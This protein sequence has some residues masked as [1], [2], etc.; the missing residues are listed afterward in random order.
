MDDGYLTVKGHREASNG[1]SR[2]S[3]KFSQTF[4]LDPSVDLDK[5]TASLKNGVLVV[6]APKDM[7]KLEASIRR[8]P[9]TAGSPAVE[10][11][12]AKEAKQGVEI[13]VSE[14]DPETEA[15]DM[16]VSADDV[17]AE[18]SDEIDLDKAGN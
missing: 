1:S 3:S 16:A 15:R 14:T 11:A 18:E 5:F 12:E 2:Y 8:I 17:D 9:I 6:S 13:P 4:S 7:K 10:E